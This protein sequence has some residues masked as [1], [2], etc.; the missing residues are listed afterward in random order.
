M[1]AKVG[2]ESELLE[3]EV[4]GEIS[5]SATGCIFTSVLSSLVAFE[6]SQSP[7]HMMNSAGLR[8]FPFTIVTGRLGGPTPFL[9]GFARCAQRM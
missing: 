7:T 1:K 6:S 8:G 3:V 2:S 5:E 9:L 4:K